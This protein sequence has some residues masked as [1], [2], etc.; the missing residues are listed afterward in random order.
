MTTPLLTAII[1]TLTFKAQPA[2]ILPKAHTSL[3][4]DSLT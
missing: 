3:T 4:G 2:N 1:H